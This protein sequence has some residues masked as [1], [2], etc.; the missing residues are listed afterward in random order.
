MRGLIVAIVVALSPGASADAT[1]DEDAALVHLDRGIS[2]FNAKNFPR[3]HREFTSAHELV[4]DKPN[5]LRWLALTEIQ[6]GDC[7]SAVEHI[8]GF[9]TRVPAS[10]PRVAEMTRWREF[11]RREPAKPAAPPPPPP[12]SDKP[13]RKSWWFWP[14]VGTAAVAVTGVGIYAATHGE[15]STLPAIRCDANGCR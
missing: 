12:P 3:A 11:C 2:A 14:L 5:P 8:D 13:L 15:S 9:V 1:S 6:L 7:A 4:P 10:D